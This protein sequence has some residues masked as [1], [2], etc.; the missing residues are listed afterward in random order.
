LE[1]NK[2]AGPD[3]CSYV[4]VKHYSYV[5]VNTVHV[6]NRVTQRLDTMNSSR[7]PQSSR[8]PINFIYLSIWYTFFFALKTLVRSRPLHMAEIAPIAPCAHRF[9]PRIRRKRLGSARALPSIVSLKR[10]SRGLGPFIFC[11]CLVSLLS[12]D[13]ENCITVATE[14]NSF[15]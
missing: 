14:L 15:S 13:D 11:I 10:V 2:K 4:R 12:I 8:K 1:K 3:H 9:H 7:A 6:L 5:H